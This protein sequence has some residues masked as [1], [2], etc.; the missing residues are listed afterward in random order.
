MKDIS[1]DKKKE[2]KMY[3][4]DAMNKI[5]ESIDYNEYSEV[6]TSEYFKNSLYKAEDEIDKMVSSPLMTN[7]KKY[8]NKKLSFSPKR[9]K[10]LIFKRIQ[11][12]NERIRNRESEKKIKIIPESVKEKLYEINK[13]NIKTILKNKTDN[14]KF[15]I[16]SQ[17]ILPKINSSSKTIE[18]NTNNRTYNSQK[19]G[20]NIDKNIEEKEKEKY[21][22][23]EPNNL[24]N[25]INN[26]IN[27]K[28]NKDYYNNNILSERKR[29]V[30]IEKKNR[31]LPYLEKLASMDFNSNRQTLDSIY[32]K[33]IKELENLRLYKE[34]ESERL[35]KINL[36]KKKKDK[37]LKNIMFKNRDKIMKS[38]LNENIKE[39]SKDKN[40]REQKIMKDYVEMKLKKDPIIK[41]SEKFAYANRKPLLTLFH[42]DEE[43][44]IIKDGPLAKL[45]VKDKKIL[46]KLD[47]DNRNTRLLMKRLDEDQEKYTSGGYFFMTKDQD[48]LSQRNN[49]RLILDSNTNYQVDNGFLRSFN[50]TNLKGFDTNEN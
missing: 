33:S 2:A 30:L 6:N 18:F 22:M 26:S 43:K 25:S 19:N 23:T 13:D 20:L 16:N 39:L 17:N 7:Y 14:Q 34:K 21:M 28:L 49:F 15:Y 47:D 32:L 11:W 24:S 3:F 31:D 1:P 44:K 38:F 9:K 50:F 41:L 36:L 5:D 8:K 35:K 46:K 29:N 10:N 45:K 48:N 12:L 42:Y 4:S 37:G 40:N 27:R